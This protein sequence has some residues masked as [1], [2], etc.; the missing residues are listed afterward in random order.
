MADIESSVK[1]RTEE[2]SVELLEVLL[3]DE[4]KYSEL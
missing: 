4:P 2:V 3:N 1:N